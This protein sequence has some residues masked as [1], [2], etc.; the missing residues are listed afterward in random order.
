MKALTSK[1]SLLACG[2]RLSL[3]LLLS[4]SLLALPAFATDALWENSATITVAPQIDASNFVNT[5]TISINTTL[6]FETAHTLNFT[7]SGTMINSPGWLFDDSAPST[8]NRQSAD[9]FIN[10]NGGLVQSLDSLGLAFVSIGIGTGTSST[11]YLLVDASNVVNKGTLSVGG[12]GLLKITGTNVNMARGALD[13]TPIQSTGSFVIGGTNFLND[14][15]ITDVYWGQTNGLAF[16]SATI[17]N[18]TTA[19]APRHPVQMGVGGPTIGTSFSVSQPFVAGYS[20]ATQLAALTLTNSD[21][22]F[23]NIL[24]PTNIIKQAVFVGISDTNIMSVAVTFLPSST[25][26]NPF[27]TVSVQFALQSTNVITGNIEVTPLYFYDTLA[28]ET[29]RG[30]DFNIGA[31][32]ERPANYGLSR[33]DDGRFAA[34]APGNVTPDR[35]FLYDPAT[36]TNAIVVGEYAGYA[37]NVD[38]LVSEPPPTTGGAVTNFP[39][40]VQ[41][42]ADTLD[43]TATRV[44]GQG[45]IIVKANHLLSSAGAALD[46]E[47]LSFD[48]GSSNGLLNFSG[49]SK[50]S[51]I[52]LKG[53][54]L[55]WSGLWSN[56]MNIVITNNFSVTNTFDTNGVPISTNATP[57]PLTITVSI[58]LYALVLDGSQLAAR[59]PVITWDLV[60]HGTDVVL[61]DSMNLVDALLL[62]GQSLTINGNVALTSTTLQNNSGQSV[63]TALND[64]VFTNAPNLLFF[65]NNGSLTVPKEAHFGDDRPVPYSDFV[66]AGTLRA[67]SITVDSTYIENDSVI[68]ANVGPLTL[69]G[70]IGKFQGGQ[71]TS[72]GDVDLNFTDLK[73]FSHRISA[74]GVLNFDV[75]DAL[76]D[77]GPTSS[78]VFVTRFGFNLME[79]PNTGDLLGTTFQDS[80]PNFAE[81][82]HTW[83]GQDRGASAS[84]YSDNV[85]LGKLILAI[86]SAFPTQFPLFVF[87]GANGQNGLYVDLLDLTSLGTNY[88]SMLQINPSIT[89]YYA[90]AKL[91]FTPPPNSAGIPQEPEEFLNGQF[92]GHLVW[93]SSFAGPNSSTAVLVNGVTVLMNTALRNS[94][95]I[96]SDGDGIPNFYDSTPLGGSTPTPPGGSLVLGPGLLNRVAPQP[97]FSLNWNALANTAYRVEM[98]TDLAHPNWQLVTTY[99][100][101]SPATANVTISDTNN[102]STRQRFYRVRVSP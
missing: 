28:A 56:S 34:G 60:T 58:G 36:F 5:G 22:S 32:G 42:S 74:S 39:G 35:A 12:G 65:T 73:F 62:D 2:G 75:S 81:V 53:E 47:N 15:G 67:G 30:L 40:R 83:A 51:V 7:N 19:T 89:I 59:L 9:N 54:L 48:L 87:S 52:R 13:V 100:N 38:N 37:A 61:N 96:D 63:T 77:A 86:S 20:N 78:N 21:G 71:T 99:T 82:D 72:R 17:Y 46:C 41:I 6:P 23:T 11:S 26:T 44:R 95:I 69:T 27:Q 33:I 18:G 92:G 45:A 84:G 8:G 14:A 98:T 93:V 4:S 43:M 79:K 1:T 29:N 50:Q 90:A 49:L 101:T 91:G 64:W 76:S 57:V 70:N 88:L 16:N 80:A 94:K 85:A 3:C 66:N 31:A 102:V 10:L 55:A 97:V 25:F 24:V 68:S